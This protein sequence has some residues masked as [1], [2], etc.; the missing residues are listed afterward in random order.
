[1]NNESKIYCLFPSTQVPSWHKESQTENYV[2]LW[3]SGKSTVW[4][5]MTTPTTTIQSA[6]C[7]TQHNAW[8]GNFSSPGWIALK[9]ITVRRMGPNS[10]CK[11]LKSIFFSKTFTYK[12]LE[13]SRSRSACAFSSFMREYSDPVDKTDRCAEYVDD[14]RIAAKNATDVTRNI[15]PAFKCIPQTGMKLTLEKTI[16]E[17]GKLI[18]W[19]GPYRKKEL[20]RKL[21]KF[22]EFWA[23]SDFPNQKGNAALPGNCRLLQKVFSQDGWKNY[24]ILQNAESR[25]DNHYHIRI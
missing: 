19:E 2:C 3:I 15:Q 9:L 13:Q 20:H 24:P 14:L 1:M 5:H 7:Q 22:K 18:S 11:L 4:L 21:G 16:F 17:S 8:Q 23:I 10:Q 12:R 6:L 25:N